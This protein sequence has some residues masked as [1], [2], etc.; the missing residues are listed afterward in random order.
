MAGC[1]DTAL[2]VQRF[3]RAGLR[4]RHRRLVRYSTQHSVFSA[5]CHISIVQ[6]P[7]SVVDGRPQV[8]RPL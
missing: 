3:A 6:A 4:R 7:L 1:I 8:I 2:R 5:A